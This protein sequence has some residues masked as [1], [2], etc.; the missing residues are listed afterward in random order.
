[1][2]YYRGRDLAELRRDLVEQRMRS[3][4]VEDDLAEFLEHLSANVATVLGLIPAS[5][6]K[7]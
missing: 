3:R 1:M 2:R 5:S 6:D 4:Q 7:V